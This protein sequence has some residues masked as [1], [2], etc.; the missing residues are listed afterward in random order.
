[1]YVL[2]RA[3]RGTFRCLIMDVELGERTTNYES[4]QEMLMT[5]CES[6]EVSAETIRK[7]INTTA[8]LVNSYDF[9]R[10]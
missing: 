7:G 1:M 3:K 5:S 2:E 10:V 9:E 6:N 8:R 4:Y